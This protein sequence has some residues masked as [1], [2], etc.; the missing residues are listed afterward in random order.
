MKSLYES[1]LGNVD[2]IMAAAD[3][4]VYSSLLT[5]KKSE[6]WQM[7][8]SAMLK[9]SKSP[10]YAIESNRPHPDTTFKKGN[11]LYIDVP[12]LDFCGLNKDQF[13]GKSLKDFFPDMTRFE[14]PGGF[15]ARWRD[16]SGKDF[17]DEIWCSTINLVDTQILSDITFH[18]ISNNP[19]T[20]FKSPKKITRIIFDSDL[21]KPTRFS[22]VKI[23]CDEPNFSTLNFH[24]QILN[25]LNGL[26]SNAHTILFHDTM[27]FYDEKDCDIISS[28]FDWSWECPVFDN[29]KKTMAKYPVKNLKKLVAIA[30]NPKR[31]NPHDFIVKL[32]PGTRLSNVFNIGGFPELECISIHSNNVEIRFIKE[33][34]M[35]VPSLYYWMSK[36]MWVWDKKRNAILDGLR[37][38][39]KMEKVGVPKTE[40]GWYVGIGKY[41]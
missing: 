4:S 30:N 17:G 18:V 39:A 36:P 14:I 24:T 27:M 38:D 37:G 34:S 10:A 23:I 25:N 32:N 41:N 29:S 2:D 7:H 22:N 11:T 3:D 12:F 20:K 26:E 19:H 21:S 40:D 15:F 9:Y 1:I 35:K 13:G 5:D 6:F 28:L 16:V 8:D 31:Y 33:G